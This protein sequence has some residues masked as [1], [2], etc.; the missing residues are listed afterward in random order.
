[1]RGIHDSFLRNCV[2]AGPVRVS[3]MLASVAAG[4]VGLLALA[5]CGE[6]APPSGQPAAA[7]PHPPAVPPRPGGQ[8]PVQQPQAPGQPQAAAPAPGAPAPAPES[9]QVKPRPVLGRTTQDIREVSTELEKGA[10]KVDTKIT[11]EDYITVVGN[12]YASIV[13]RMEILQIKHS[14]DLF[15]AEHDRYP[16]DREEFMKEIIKA[17]GLRLAQLPAYQEYGYDSKTHDLVILEYPAKKAA[18]LK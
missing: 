10:Q 3:T 6:T 18:L 7:N 5:G 4:L 16:K 17:N 9:E 1:M 13:G 12:A 11:G 2:V 8:A 15:H 14:V